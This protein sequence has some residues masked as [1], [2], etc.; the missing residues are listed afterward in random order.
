M[1]KAKVISRIVCLLLCIIPV[2]SIPA[3]DGYCVRLVAYA[4]VG[5]HE[6]GGNN[7]GFDDPYFQ[8]LMEEVGWKP[9]YQWCAFF[10]R[11]I[12]HE[13]GVEAIDKISGWS[14][15]CSN[16]KDVIFTDGRFYQSY[17]PGDVLVMTLSYSHWKNSNR[18]KAIG[19][20]GIV[21]KISQY[22]VR[23]IEGNTNDRG[24]RDS[25]SGD[26][27]LVKIRPLNKSIHITRWHK[28]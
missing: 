5:I 28:Q 9:T 17:N 15:T 18:I 4:H 10:V 2:H 6:K 13:C 25:R 27:V 19:H 22:S 23:T 24:D 12:F 1:A 16:K 20:T 21:D 8:R 3:N 11:A 26:A 14:P 7:M